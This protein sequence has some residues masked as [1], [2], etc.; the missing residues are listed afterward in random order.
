M[1][2]LSATYV[3]ASVVA[4]QYYWPNLFWGTYLDWLPRFRAGQTWDTYWRFKAIQ[5]HL[6]AV[7]TAPATA[8]HCSMWDLELDKN[9]DGLHTIYGWVDAQNGFG[10]LIRIRYL[11]GFE[12]GQVNQL[13]SFEFLEQK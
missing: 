7:L 6:E 5:R 1:L 13:R 11:A 10:A 9:K 3:G 12:Q 8:Q 4:N 2:L